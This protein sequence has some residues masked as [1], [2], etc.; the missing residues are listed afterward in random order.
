M[1][2][3]IMRPRPRKFTRQHGI[4]LVLHKTHVINANQ[5]SLEV[6]F[7]GC[8]GSL[9]SSGQASIETRPGLWHLQRYF[10]TLGKTSTR[11]KSS[12]PYKLTG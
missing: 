11:I 1:N 5:W 8:W 3:T 6:F 2:T 4:T 12:Y 9:G 10:C 7:S